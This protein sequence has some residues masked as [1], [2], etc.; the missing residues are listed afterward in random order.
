[1]SSPSWMALRWRFFFVC[2][3]VVLAVGAASAQS[4]PS[5]S[6]DR[7]DLLQPGESSSSQ[8]QVVADDG[9]GGADELH[10][11]VA[12]PGSGGGA[13]AG[14]YQEHGWK[15]NLSQQLRP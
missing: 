1:M 10:P 6:Q 14:Q 15:S 3:A 12:A 9:A 4:S 5:P 7:A 13:A 8:F 2:G 11:A